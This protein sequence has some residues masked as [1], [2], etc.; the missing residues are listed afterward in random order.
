MGCVR[1]G[2]LGAG[3]V[4]DRQM[5]PNTRDLPN[6]R[7]QAVMVRDLGRAQ[8][9][10]EKYRAPRGYDR[11]QDLLADPEVDAVYVA[12]PVNHHA[13]QVIAAAE[14][15][16]HVLC[17]KPMALNAEQCREMIAAC[18]ANGVKLMVC[19]PLR[20]V[21]VHQRM[22]EIVRQ[23]ELG[24]IVLARVQL[25]KW[26]PLD[27]TAWRSDPAQAG[28]GVLMDLGSHLFD[29]LRFVVDEIQEVSAALSNRTFNLAVEDTAT[30]RVRFRNGGHGLIDT[31]FGVFRA[32]NQIEIY[33]TR[34]TLL[35]GPGEG[36]PRLFTAA[37]EQVLPAEPVHP[38]R[39]EMEHFSRCILEDT[40][41]LST[42]WDGLRN[43]TLIQ[44]AY[45]SARTGQA[46]TCPET[47]P[48]GDQVMAS[49]R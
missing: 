18:A 34:G 49:G 25:A 31:S 5:L 40:E 16:K 24:E 48:P 29:F 9:L 1:W 33:G 32:S 14:H 4:A 38:Y 21:P 42:G 45:E 36:G 35:R 43:I 47:P 41:P 13:A 44:A 30:V 17:E 3:G 46:V 8:Q 6:A 22:R 26:Y 10:A 23:G 15:G 12:T 39:A 37:G 27:P 7:L 2:V 20:F 19:F 28:G 11:V